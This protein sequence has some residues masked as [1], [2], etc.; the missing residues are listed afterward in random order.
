MLAISTRLFTLLLSFALMFGAVPLALAQSVG[1]PSPRLLTTTPMGGKAGTQFEVVITG[2]NLDD[3]EE[4]IF[5]DK[6]IYATRKVD[7]SGVLIP[8]HYMVTIAPDCPVGIYESR[9]MTRLGVSSS[10]IFTVGQFPE[11]V[12]S[13]SNKTLES[14]VELPVGS[15]FNGTISERS[16]DYFKFIGKKGQRLVVDC[17]S[18]GIDSKL[19]ATVIIADEAGRDLLV[20]R[21]GGVLEYSVPKD[22]TYVIKIHELTFKGGPAFYYRWSTNYSTAIHKNCQ[23][24]FMASNRD[25]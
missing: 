10:R 7:S 15:I 19:N 6:R 1:L 2:E 9:I 16:V 23:F 22:G 8:D 5:S 13:K 3:A 24:I 21:L 20:E 11:F 12:Q 18:N 25:F 17:A 14:A 4:L